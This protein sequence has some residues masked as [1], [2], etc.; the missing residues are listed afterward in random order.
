MKEAK[1]SFATLESGDLSLYRNE[2]LMEIRGELA[3]RYL[4]SEGRIEE[5]LKYDDQFQTAYKVVSDPK[6]YDRLLNIKKQ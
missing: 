2:I 6:V 1:D 4:G 5:L 3:S